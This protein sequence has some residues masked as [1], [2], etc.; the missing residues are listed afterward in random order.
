MKHHH[1]H[2]ALLIIAASVT[3]FVYALYGYM[4]STVASSLDRVLAGRSSIAQQESSLNQENSLTLLHESTA[5]DRSK[6]RSFFVPDNETVSFIEAVEALGANTGATITLSSIDADNLENE[7]A[8][9]IGH[10]RAHV[11]VTGSWAAVMKTLKLAEVSP[12]GVSV[13]KVRV[14]SSG[15]VDAKAGQRGWKASFVIDAL[16]LRHTQ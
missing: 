7:K 1:S 11:D 8:G 9:S 5:Q 2:I 4:H 3:L 6:L 15:G 10:I 12:Y 16:L 13:S 14:D